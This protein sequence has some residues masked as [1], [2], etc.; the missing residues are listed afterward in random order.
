[1]EF[2]YT[3][4]RDDDTLMGGA[5]QGYRL[6]HWLADVLRNWFSDPINIKDERISK[7]LK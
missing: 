6:I 7:L 4:K 2:D 3:T 1:M 5:L